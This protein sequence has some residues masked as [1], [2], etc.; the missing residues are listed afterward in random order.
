ML[1]GAPPLGAMR[2][3]PRER[4]PR[5]TAERSSRGSTCYAGVASG[6]WLLISWLT[7]GVVASQQEEKLEQVSGTADLGDQLNKG[8]RRRARGSQDSRD[9]S[10]TVVPT[11]D[12]ASGTTP[13]PDLRALTNAS[14]A[15]S[16]AAAPRGFSAA[17]SEADQS[18]PT[19][20]GL[21]QSV[22]NDSQSSVSRE[23]RSRVD[24]SVN[25]GLDGQKGASQNVFNIF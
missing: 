13:M 10:L 2:G 12:T 18:V 22:R 6:A 5:T 8:V 23:Q 1:R 7:C 3:A 16:A 14:E 17:R 4:R 9:G 15:A 11:D 19:T 20:R 25:Q 24:G 21:D